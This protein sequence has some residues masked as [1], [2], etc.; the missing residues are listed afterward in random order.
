[1]KTKREELQDNLDEYSTVYSKIQVI[2]NMAQ[3]R[4]TVKL[5]ILI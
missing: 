3:L 2:K 1:M 5:K 4:W